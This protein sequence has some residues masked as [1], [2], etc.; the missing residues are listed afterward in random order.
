MWRIVSER[1]GTLSMGSRFKKLKYEGSIQEVN[2]PHYCV[3][4][5]RDVSE[6]YS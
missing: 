5:I 2:V 4:Y 1:A 3:Q 6:L